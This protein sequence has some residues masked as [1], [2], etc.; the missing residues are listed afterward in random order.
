MKRPWWQWWF[1]YSYECSVINPPFL[2]FSFFFWTLLIHQKLLGRLRAQSYCSSAPTLCQEDVCCDSAIKN[3]MSAKREALAWRQAW[4]GAGPPCWSGRSLK[5]SASVC[6][7]VMK[8]R[9]KRTGSGKQGGSKTRWGVWQWRCKIYIWEGDLDFK[10]GYGTMLLGLGKP[11]L[12]LALFTICCALFPK[13]D[14]G[15]H[16]FALSC[17]LKG[18]PVVIDITG[19]FIKTRPHWFCA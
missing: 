2:F 18:Y 10:K 17:V 13:P 16:I 4:V 14:K 3:F 19:S 8:M 5:P 9:A 6:C 15:N 11:F 7:R 1:R 12:F